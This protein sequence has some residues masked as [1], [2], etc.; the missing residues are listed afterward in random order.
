MANNSELICTTLPVYDHV[1]YR[2]TTKDEILYPGGMFSKGGKIETNNLIWDQYYPL[3][4]YRDC[5]FD[6]FDC[7]VQVPQRRRIRYRQNPDVDAWTKPR[8]I[9]L[10]G[11]D[12]PKL[13]ETLLYIND[14]PYADDELHDDDIIVPV[15]YKQLLQQGGEPKMING[16][17]RSDGTIFDFTGSNCKG[18]CTW[19]FGPSTGL[20]STLPVNGKYENGVWNETDWYSFEE[21]MNYKNANC[22]SSYIPCVYGLAFS[23]TRQFCWVDSVSIIYSDTNGQ[24]FVLPC[25]ILDGE[26]NCVTATL[27]FFS[28]MSS[29]APIGD[30]TQWI[31]DSFLENQHKWFC[32]GFIMTVGVSQSYPGTSA[33]MGI[34]RVLPLISDTNCP[35]NTHVLINDPKTTDFS[36]V[37]DS[38][39]SN[40]FPPAGNLCWGYPPG[41][42]LE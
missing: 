28:E 13:H 25:E 21:K 12:R 38:I 11:V 9:S 15:R 41:G 6:S 33:N 10:T 26:S 8:Y 40:T 14:D 3:H 20:D 29:I 36:V 4:Y 35:P 32:T 22:K 7:F 17:Y 30:G 2:P 16:D 18:K 5:L 23:M 42:N 39:N 37:S 31:R 34:D 27:H 24:R 1:N 19:V